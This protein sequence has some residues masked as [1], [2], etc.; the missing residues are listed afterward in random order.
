MHG[1]LDYTYSQLYCM[2]NMSNLEATDKTAEN[3]CTVVG[4]LELVQGSLKDDESNA[5]ECVRV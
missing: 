1:L 5:C 4:L 2:C 3:H